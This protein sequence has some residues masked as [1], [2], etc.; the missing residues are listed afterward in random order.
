MTQ[1][2]RTVTRVNKEIVPS[3][4]YTRHLKVKPVLHDAIT[5][6]AGVHYLH[7]QEATEKLLM[8]GFEVLGSKEIVDEI[9]R[10]KGNKIKRYLHKLFVH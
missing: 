7:L 6:W 9:N 3:R 10:K 8:A 1:G 2:K 4:E 5:V